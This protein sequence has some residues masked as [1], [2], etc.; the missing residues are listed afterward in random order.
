MTASS[1]VGTP[2]PAERLKALDE[3]PCLG[4][5]AAAERDRHRRL[6]QP[7]VVGLLLERPGDHV[8]GGGGPTL[9][10]PEEGEARLGSMA[11]R[12]GLGVCAFGLLEAAPDPVLLGLLV[13]GV[14]DGRIDRRSR[15]HEPGALHLVGGGR[16][17]AVEAH[18]LGAEDEAMAAEHEVGMRGTP[19]R[20]RGRPFL[21][22][23]DVE[24]RVAVFD[25]RAVHHPGHRRRHLAGRHAGH[26]LVEEADPAVALAQR[27]Q[28]LAAPQ[29]PERRQVG[30]AEALGDR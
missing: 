3:R 26:R 30:V 15:E 24:D 25:G 16:P 11:E 14:A 5:V 17:V 12:A 22:P 13:V 21:R 6:E 20:E 8:A 9:G 29:P 7:R 19:V 23:P 1:S 27:D 4:G 18:E 2:L 10:E 28:R